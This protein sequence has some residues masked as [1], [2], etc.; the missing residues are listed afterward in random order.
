LQQSALTASNAAR[1]D[2]VAVAKLTKRYA[3]PIVR[4]TVNVK[5]GT[6]QPIIRQRKDVLG[7]IEELDRIAINAWED[8]EFVNTVR[9]TGY[10]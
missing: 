7:E 3:L 9:A 5:T 10:K 8:E 6:C 1:K 2:I 4:S